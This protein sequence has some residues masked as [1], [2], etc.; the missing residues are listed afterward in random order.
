MPA[1]LPPQYHEAERN[2]R[3]AKT[4]QE[5]IAYLEEMLA[6]MPKHKGTDHLR[7]ELRAKLANLTKSLDK[8]AATQRASLIVEKAG[9]AQVAVIGMPNTGKSQLVASLTNARPQVA[10]YPFTTKTPIPGMMKFE[11]VQ[12]QLVDTPPLSDSPPEW[13][14]LNIIRRADGLAVVVDLGQDAVSQAER[15]FSILHGK[16][17]MVFGLDGEPGDEENR[18]NYKRAMIIANKSDLD[19]AQTNFTLLK[20]HYEAKIPVVA[21][22]ALSGAG[23]EELKKQLFRML[24]LIRVYTKPPGG[25]ADFNEPIVLEQGSTVEDAA[26]SIHRSFASR[27][28]FARIWGSGKFDG[29]MVRR[30]YVL[31]DGDVIELHM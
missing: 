24:N 1:N 23:L 22:S 12:I 25:K 10:P 5:K 28:K 4:T 11:N 7:A 13:W 14:L 6:I 27:L 8:K 26:A 20:E 29:I 9:A 31:E 18:A 2:F 17:L 30:D 3:L 16:R 19:I 15:V 21:V